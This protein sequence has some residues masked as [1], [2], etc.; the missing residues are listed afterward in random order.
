LERDIKKSRL[1]HNVA[2]NEHGG[3]KPHWWSGE[4]LSWA[5]ESVAASDERLAVV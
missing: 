5:A 3:T 4:R 1:L 2:M